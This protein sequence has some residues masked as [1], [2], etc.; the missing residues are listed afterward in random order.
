VCVCQIVIKVTEFV[1]DTEWA[2][3]SHAM[4]EASVDHLYPNSFITTVTKDTQI[5]TS[6]FMIP[7]ITFHYAS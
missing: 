2:Q 7:L 3:C 1:T 5:T 4:N 6:F